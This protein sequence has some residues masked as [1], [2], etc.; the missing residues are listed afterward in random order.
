[1]IAGQKMLM[2][3]LLA[4]ASSTT[5]GFT[6]PSLSSNTGALRV[7]HQPSSSQL[8]MARTLYGHPGT[9]SP[10]CNW[11]AN[12]VGLD[13]V[14]GDLAQNPHPF[15]QLP[16]L[17][18]DGDVLVFESGAI[19]QYFHTLTMDNYSAKDAAAITSW[20]L[21]AN[22]SLDPVCFL[23][24][25]DGKVYD[26]GLKKPNKRI[27]TLDD[28]LKEQQYLLGTQFTLADVAVASYLLYVMQF[29]QGI[30]IAGKWPNVARYMKDCAARDGYAEAF[31]KNVQ[32]A[33]VG[34]LDKQMQGKKFFGMF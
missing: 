33:L 9:R 23:E 12:E 6:T 11:G 16:C 1:M 24:T 19:L 30:D 18:D 31:G 28:L 26:T 32:T 2:L 13:F 15:G 5:Q 27:Q 22:A 4:I 20:I 3:W 14:M 8:D 10:L 17:T 29:F 21:W 25:P 7:Q 34:A